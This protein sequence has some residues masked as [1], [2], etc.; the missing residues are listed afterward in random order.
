MILKENTRYRAAGRSGWCG[1]ARKGNSK[2]E[3]ETR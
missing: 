2:Q 1:K 3:R